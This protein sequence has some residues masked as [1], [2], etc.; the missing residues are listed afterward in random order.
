MYRC[1]VESKLNIFLVINDLLLFILFGIAAFV[2]CA[3]VTYTIPLRQLPVC[4]DIS[5]S[6]P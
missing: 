6:P 4:S 2:Y 5:H 1:S 3:M